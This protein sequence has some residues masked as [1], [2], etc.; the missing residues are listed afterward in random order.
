MTYKFTLR[1]LINIAHIGSDMINALIVAS[2]NMGG[3]YA[4]RMDSFA[5]YLITKNPVLA[6]AQMDWGSSSPVE[7]NNSSTG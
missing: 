4:E 6:G 1:S 5:S 3:E 2:A 7:R